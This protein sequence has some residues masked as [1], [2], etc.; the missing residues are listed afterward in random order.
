MFFNIQHQ[1][2]YRYSHPVQLGPQQLRFRPRDDGSQRVISYQLDIVPTPQGRNEYLD[3]EGNQVT[4]VWFDRQ[5][6][7]FDITASMQVQTIR[8]NA[9]DF[10]LAPD[11][12]VLPIDHAHDIDCARAYLARI[13][14]DD[15]VTAFAAE[16]SIAADRNTLSFIDQLNR[17]LSAEFMQIHRDT[18]EPQSPAFTLQHRQG[19]CRDLAVLFVDCCRAEGLA[20]RFAS[21]YQRGN[22]LS[23]RRHLH[24]W[25][26]VYLPG[27]GWRGFDPTHGLALADTH[28]TIAAAAHARDTMPVSG[29]FNGLG[30]SSTLDYSVQI[31]V[32]DN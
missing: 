1:T 25:P 8:S 27:G 19:A 26:E 11:A 30:A 2:R 32:S 6:E 17:Q 28:V 16:L 5:T 24:A 23:E 3:L 29:V 9:F 12:A 4:Q 10:L 31:Q 14:P 15:S 20:A 21:G 13:E 7:S 18:G 22:L